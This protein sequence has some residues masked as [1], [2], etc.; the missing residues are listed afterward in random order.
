MTRQSSNTPPSQNSVS[1]SVY[2]M[3]PTVVGVNTAGELVGPSTSSWI[4]PLDLDEV[5]TIDGTATRQLTLSHLRTDCPK[6][7]EP[8]AIATMLD[9][10]CD[11]IL[12]APRQVRSWANP[13]NACGRFG[14]FD[15]PYAV[16]PV[17]GLI[18]T[19]TGV[20]TSSVSLPSSEAP[21]VPTD[22]TTE[23]PISSAPSLPESTSQSAPATSTSPVT[24]S[25]SKLAG[26]VVSMALTVLTA[27]LMI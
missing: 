20:I 21:S 12:A 4:L 13:C 14:L 5:S 24:A 19:T 7:A 25:A 9:S 15:P 8:S 2:M 11:P 1:P 3:I 10:A 26:G 6:T 17:T 23:V 22:P 18:A 27:L 16:P